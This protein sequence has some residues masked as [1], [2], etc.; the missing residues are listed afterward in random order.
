MGREVIIKGR[1]LKTEGPDCSAF[2]PPLSRLSHNN[3]QFVGIFCSSGSGASNQFKG[4]SSSMSNIHG[5]HSFNDNGS[6]GAGG[7]RSGGG[8]G[9]YAYAGGGPEQGF[10]QQFPIPA[11]H[12]S[13]L[14]VGGGSFP[15]LCDLFCPRYR[16]LC[17]TTFISVVQCIML[18]VCLIGGC[19][20]FVYLLSGKLILIRQP[21]V[22]AEMFDGA[23]VKG[24]DMG[25]PG[26]QTFLYMGAKYLPDIKEGQVFRFISPIL[27]HGG[28][29]HLASNLFFQC[30]VGFIFE[31]RWGLVNYVLI[32]LLTGLGAS[33]FSCL[34]SPKSISV[35]ASGALFGLVRSLRSQTGADLS[36]LIM[37]WRYLPNQEKFQE[38]CMVMCVIIINF[39]IGMTGSGNIDNSA[40]FG[41]V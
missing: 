15:E 17:F 14:R 20:Y 3:C 36:Y 4:G 29:L 1:R 31:L 2:V 13:L 22:G 24:N 39:L 41:G 21:P 10:N 38:L 18:V 30:R 9:G 28:I 40:H 7:A 26:G 6:G 5:V 27:L 34:I 33:Y 25:G 12:I 35:G 19:V 11:G 23:F 37:N 32:Y 8:R 16:L